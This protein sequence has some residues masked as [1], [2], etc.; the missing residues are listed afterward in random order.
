MKKW[1]RPKL[2]VLVRSKPE[3]SVLETCKIGFQPGPA[4]AFAGCAPTVGSVCFGFAACE[5]DRE[6]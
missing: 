2:V 6:S 4:A 3:E 5:I 1:E